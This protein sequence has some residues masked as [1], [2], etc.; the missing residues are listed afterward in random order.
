M[1][2]VYLLPIIARSTK[3]PTLAVSYD[4]CLSAAYCCQ[5]YQ[6]AYPGSAVKESASKPKLTVY[7]YCHSAN[8]DS[9]KKAKVN[10]LTHRHVV[11]HTVLLVYSF[12]SAHIT[13]GNVN[14]IVSYNHMAN[15]LFYQ[16]ALTTKLIPSLEK[17]LFYS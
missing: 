10:T 13:P 11:F 6:V 3:W 1:T 17:C 9:P 8:N 12:S 7:E 5:K 14:P 4:L 16:L 2:C 15:I